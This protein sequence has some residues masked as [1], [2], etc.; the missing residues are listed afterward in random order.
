MADDEDIAALVV[1]NGSGMCK[2]KQ[3]LK[4]SSYSSDRKR[5]QQF[6]RRKTITTENEYRDASKPRTQSTLL[7]GDVRSIDNVAQSFRKALS[8][9]RIDRDYWNV[10][11]S[12]QSFIFCRSC[13]LIVTLFFRISLLIL[14]HA[15]NLLHLK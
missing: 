8:A 2:G 10:M 14:H 11:A 13:Q 6:R 9:K 5:R 4:V 1:D 7:M 12:R 15:T 3:R